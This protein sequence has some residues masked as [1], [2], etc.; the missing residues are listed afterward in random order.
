MSKL[1]LTQTQVAWGL[2]V[3]LPWLSV[4]L[5]GR[6]LKETLL[7]PQTSN[8]PTNHQAPCTRADS[9]SAGPGW[10]PRLCILSHP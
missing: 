10:G 9:E 3:M 4:L 1:L 7:F 6:T 8:V 2:S 5:A